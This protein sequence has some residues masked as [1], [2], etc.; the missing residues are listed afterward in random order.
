[1]FY[2][3]PHLKPTLP[4]SAVNWPHHFLQ[5][6]WPKFVEND[7]S[8]PSKACEILNNI[9]SETLV[10]WVAKQVFCFEILITG[11][12]SEFWPLLNC[13]LILFKRLESRIWQHVN[14]KK[15]TDLFLLVVLHPAY[16]NEVEQLPGNK[17][18]NVDVKDEPSAL[19]CRTNDNNDDQSQRFES[20]HLCFVR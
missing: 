6:L 17:M 3:L 4:V 18:N 5:K 11:R 15:H 19:S 14:L 2:T 1:M 13:L 8:W 7:A 16:I 20:F 10:K 9:K 12:D